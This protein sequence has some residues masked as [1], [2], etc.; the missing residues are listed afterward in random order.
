MQ[1][2][3]VDSYVRPRRSREPGVRWVPPSEA[4]A[5]RVETQHRELQRA[6]ADESI[7]GARTGERR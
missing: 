2:A 5:D 3:T 4:Y 1:A 7:P 6:V